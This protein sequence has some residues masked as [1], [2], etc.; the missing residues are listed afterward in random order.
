M[1][2]FCPLHWSRQQEGLNLH[3]L[4]LS[5]PINPLNAEIYLQITFLDI[6]MEQVKPFKDPYIINSQ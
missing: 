6:G 4:H 2:L 5:Q 3:K 1:G